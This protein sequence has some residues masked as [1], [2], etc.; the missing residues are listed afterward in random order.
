MPAKTTHIIPSDDGWVVKQEHG[1]VFVEKQSDRQ[2]GK[3]TRAERASAVLPAQPAALKRAKQLASREKVYVQVN[4][5]VYST[6]K[7]ALD[8]ARGIA[9]RSSAGQIVVHGRD[10]FIRR[11]D[12]RGLP[13]VQT[14]PRKSKLGTKAIERAVSTVIRERLERE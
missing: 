12:I 3:K 4:N 6:Q 1:N 9:R 14:P 5:G 13:V 10:G 11:R 7:Q 2:I 8:A